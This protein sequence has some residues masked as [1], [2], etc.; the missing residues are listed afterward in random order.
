MELWLK[1]LEPIILNSLSGKARRELL[2][3]RGRLNE[4]DK[5]S[6]LKHDPIQ[7]F[8][9]SMRMRTG[10]G[11]TAITF[12]STG[13]KN[14]IKTVALDTPGMFKTQL[15]RLIRV[16]GYSCDL[17]GIP[18]VFM[19]AVTQAG[20]T[21]APDIRTR[22]IIEEWCMPIRVTFVTP[23]LN[24]TSIMQLVANAG[25]IVGLGDFRQEKGAGSFG[26]FEVVAKEECEDIIKNGGAKQQLDAIKNWECFD[27]ETE[28]M[29]SW[30]HA[31]VKRR[32]KSDMLAA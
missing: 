5:E 29:L 16:E 24:S 22:A 12:P 17:Y 1:G 25:V 21:K 4:T 8:R 7:E 18:K 28:E 10:S 3:P 2:F 19:T 27:A 30:F 15:G 26:V 20:K 9:D 13:P 11:P 14:A 6:R 31:E 32:G 23:Q